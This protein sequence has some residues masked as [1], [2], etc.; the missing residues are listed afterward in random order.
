LAFVACGEDSGGSVVER[1]G[2]ASAPSLDGST[3]EPDARGDAH[4]GADAVASGA[5]SGSDAATG[6]DSSATDAGRDAVAID[7]ANATC[8][9]SCS[10]DAECQV[11]CPAA[12]GGGANCCDVGTGVCYATTPG[13]SC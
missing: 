7:G 2:D 5:D 1:P 6:T 12:P 13:G 11:T 10:T 9:P 4:A 8:T 3:G